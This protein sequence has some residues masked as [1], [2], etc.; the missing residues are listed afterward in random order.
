V[1]KRS[2]MDAQ[3]GDGDAAAW[4]DDA[5]VQNLLA[6]WLSVNVAPWRARKGQVKH[7]KHV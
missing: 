7:D 4:L 6:T 3:R 5:A 2:L 1:V